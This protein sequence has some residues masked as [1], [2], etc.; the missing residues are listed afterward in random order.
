MLP[1]TATLSITNSGSALGPLCSRPLYTLLT[2][3]GLESSE[4][5]K[6]SNPQTPAAHSHC[7]GQ[8]LTLTIR[9]LLVCGE[10]IC[11]IHTRL[12]SPDLLCASNR[13][14]TPH[15]RPSASKSHTELSLST[16]ISIA[17]PQEAHRQ[18]RTNLA[19]NEHPWP[20]G[21]D[22]K[23]SH[24]HLPLSLLSLPPYPPFSSYPNLVILPNV[25]HAPRY[26]LPLPIK[27][28]EHTK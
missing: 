19:P 28:E 23:I 24:P 20:R 18:A 26:I 10:P 14:L 7:L 2:R 21:L 3:Q 17:R 6:D 9:A 16:G 12:V 25:G 11:I 13:A 5:N 22:K 8:G 4:L 15:H 1:A 27:G